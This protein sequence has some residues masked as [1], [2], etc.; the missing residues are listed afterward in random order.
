[1][2]ETIQ[3][4]EKTLVEVPGK[5]WTNG[6]GTD[7]RSLYLGDNFKKEDFYLITEEEYR[8]ILAREQAEAELAME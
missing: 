3:E 6:K 7:G 5:I 1:M 4:D 2:I 8:A